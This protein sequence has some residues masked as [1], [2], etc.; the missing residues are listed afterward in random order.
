MKKL[1]IVLAI[2][3]M[4]TICSCGNSEQ[5]SDEQNADSLATAEQTQTE[6]A[7]SEQSEAQASEVNLYKYFSQEEMQS[8]MD[9]A[10]KLFSKNPSNF[11]KLFVEEGFALS[12]DALEKK[13]GKAKKR[14]VVTPEP[15]PGEE[16]VY[17]TPYANLEFEQF[18]VSLDN[19]GKNWEISFF[20][21]STKGFGFAGVFV[22][23]PECNKEYILKLFSKCE[24]S[25][26]KGNSGEYLTVTLQKDPNIHISITLDD[27]GIVQSISYEAHTYAG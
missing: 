14:E 13:W 22:G 5:G 12:P 3:L 2:A 16:E 8:E 23:V 6:E 10:V 18:I 1:N 15:E 19:Y 21:T 4:A 26:E 24:V 11:G 17:S 27:N 25:E 20:K 7:T 9:K